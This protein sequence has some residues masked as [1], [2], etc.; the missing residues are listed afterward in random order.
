MVCGC[1]I[2]DPPQTNL[3]HSVKLSF[4]GGGFRELRICLQ[5]NSIGRGFS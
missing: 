5:V 4:I 3:G 2:G 1:R